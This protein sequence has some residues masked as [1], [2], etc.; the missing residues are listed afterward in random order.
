MYLICR[1]LDFEVRR[2]AIGSSNLGLST[3]RDTAMLLI[4]RLMPLLEKA[5]KVDELA[6]LRPLVELLIE[7]LRGELHIAVRGETLQSAPVA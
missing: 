7:A 1:W 3:G 5:M 2:R 6:K 4:K